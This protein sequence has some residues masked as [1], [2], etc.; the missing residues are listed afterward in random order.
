MNLL[1]RALKSLHGSVFH[2]RTILLLGDPIYGLTRGSRRVLPLA[3]VRSVLIVRPDAIGDV[4]LMSPLLRELRRNLPRAHITLVVQPRVYNL[5]ERCPYVDEVL[6]YRHPSRGYLHAVDSLG[7]AFALSAG[8]LWSRRFEMALVGRWDHGPYGASLLAY[9][10]GACHRIGFAT[11]D[12]SRRERGPEGLLLTDVIYDDGA[13]PGEQRHEVNRN[14]EP[15]RLLG[16]SVVADALEVWTDSEDEAFARRLLDDGEWIAMVPGASGG[17]RLWPVGR[18]REVADG[19]VGS[20]GAG[21]L[22][23]GGPEHRAL[24]ESIREG[25]GGRVVNV[26]GEATLRQSAALLGRCRL[27]VGGD[28]GPMHIAAAR[29]VP[30]VEISCHPQGGRRDGVNSPARFG[31]WRVPHCILQPERAAEPCTSSCRAAEPH[32]ILGITTSRVMEAAHV[33]LGRKPPAEVFG[34]DASMTND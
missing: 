2:P 4:V 3:E 17:K 28:T 25:L 26:C 32:C 13:Y 16:G 9:F 27:Y 20:H 7:R 15:L 5:V 18:Y 12:V 23:L 14:L 10:S 22:I 31:P 11:L 29:G 30:V 33:L 21:V 6:A 1:Y 8:R 19:L 34:R 24:G